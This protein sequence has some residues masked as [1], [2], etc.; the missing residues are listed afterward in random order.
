MGA[1]PPVRFFCA[2]ALTLQSTVI[3]KENLRFPGVKVAC[4]VDGSGA[5]P[6]RLSSSDQAP[7]MQERVHKV[8][9]PTKKTPTGA[10]K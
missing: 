1:G 9:D 2:I 7:E 4:G 6:N 10:L 5:H 3:R 8:H